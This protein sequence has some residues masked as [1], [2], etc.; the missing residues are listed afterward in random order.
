MRPRESV[1]ST[2][3]LLQEQVQKEEL[4]FWRAAG[5]RGPERAMRV[6]GETAEGFPCRAE[7][8]VVALSCPAYSFREGPVDVSDLSGAVGVAG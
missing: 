5:E 8:A 3:A 6:Q 7:R 1:S 2:R 4:D